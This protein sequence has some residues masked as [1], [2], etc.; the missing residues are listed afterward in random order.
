MDCITK[1]ITAL[2][3]IQDKMNENIVKVMLNFKYIIIDMNVS[4]LDEQGVLST[5]VEIA[6]YAPY[7]PMT[8]EYKQTFGSGYGAVTSHVTLH[9]TGAFHSSFTLEKEG[10]GVKLWATDSKTEELAY[11][12]GEAIF[13]VTPEHMEEI[14][15]HI[16]YPY[17]QAL[18]SK[19]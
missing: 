18:I 8:I 11:G 6:S 15:L 19:V 16:V 9:D 13:G 14:K 10:A 17:L 3:K 12:Y 7:A 4:Q 2:K 5:G 1:K